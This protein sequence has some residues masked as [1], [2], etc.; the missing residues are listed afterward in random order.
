FGIRSREEPSVTEEEVSLM[1]S[2]GT[3]AGLFRESQQEMM[4]SVIEMGERR[5]TTLMTPRPDVEWLDLTADAGEIRAKLVEHPYSRFPVCPGGFDDLIGVVHAK[6]LLASALAGPPLDLDRPSPPAPVIPASLDVLKAL[7]TFRASGATLAMVSDEFGS[8]LGL[9]TLDDVLRNILGDVAA[10]QAHAGDDPD[11]VQRPD[12]SW[13]VDGTM[14]LDDLKELLE[15]KTLHDDGED[16]DDVQT[17]GGFVMGRLGRIPR[18]GDAFESAGWRY[19]VVDMDGH[20][21]DKVLIGKM[22]GD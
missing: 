5:I 11:A 1:L 12:G 6:D 20:R 15:V 7:E 13:L 19:E 8:I 16:E 3:K 14:P 2:Q 9:V 4:E 21:V 22:T 17:V 10:A 18:A